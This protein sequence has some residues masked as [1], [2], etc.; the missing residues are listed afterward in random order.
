[1][2]VGSQVSWSVCIVGLTPEN[3]SRTTVHAAALL[4][5]FTNAVTTYEAKGTCGQLH[6]SFPL[7]SLS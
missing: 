6:K 7:L 2:E 3:V 4:S 1:M 5:F